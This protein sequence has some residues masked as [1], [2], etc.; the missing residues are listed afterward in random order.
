M[1]CIF[2]S[3]NYFGKLSLNFTDFSPACC[4]DI[5]YCINGIFVC[6]YISIACMVQLDLSI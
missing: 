1:R 2:T 5:Y 3:S 6:M 4:R